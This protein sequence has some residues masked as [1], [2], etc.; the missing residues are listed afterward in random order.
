MGKT[1]SLV[2]GANG[3]IGSHLVQ[4][5][6]A[7]GHQVRCLVRR[8]S[9]LKWLS[10]LEIDIR[11]GSL[12]DTGSLLAACRDADYVFHLAGAVKARHKADFDRHNSDGALNIA[13]AALEAAPGLRRFLFSSSQAAAGPAAALDAPVCENDECQPLSDYGKSK[14]LAEQRL[15]ILS[16]KLPLTIIRPPS[17]YG[18]RDTEVFMYFQW[19]DRGLAL[20]PGFKTR[21]A[22]LIYV[23]DLVNGMVQAAESDAALGK[24]YFLAGDRAYSWQEISGIIARSMGKRPIKVHLPL[25]L[26]HFSAILAEAGAAVTN[27]PSTFDRQKVREMSQLYWAVS[28]KAAQRD[29]GFK[30][31]YDLPRGVEETV[32]WYKDKK[33]L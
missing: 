29:F 19:I 9:D 15:R 31:E 26:A 28:T 1:I 5:L 25:F 12:D 16:D 10:C 18:P 24:T 30:S 3:F 14:L 21:Y 4:A 17:V 13:R 20:L 32:K 33:W 22:H 23:A 2:T 6:L 27:R 8:T 7:H 11:Y